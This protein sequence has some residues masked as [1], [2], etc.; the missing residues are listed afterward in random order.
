M[1]PKAKY[2]EYGTIYANECV[3]CVK[4]GTP[5]CQ[6]E[7]RDESCVNHKTL[8]DLKITGKK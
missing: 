1:R 3:D 4:E 6:L 2:R 5:F 7:I 8:Q